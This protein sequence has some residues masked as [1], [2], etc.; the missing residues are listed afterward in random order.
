MSQLE[1]APP[2]IS[3]WCTSKN[4]C[5]TCQSCCLM[6]CQAR[7]CCSRSTSCHKQACELASK[8]CMRQLA[9]YLFNALPGGQQDALHP[10]PVCCMQ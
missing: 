6:S 9:A 4:S 2:S 7:H 5:G 10:P 3:S 1:I 8:C